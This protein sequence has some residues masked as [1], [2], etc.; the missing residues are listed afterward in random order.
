MVC[1]SRAETTNQVSAQ[2]NAQAQYDLGV[3]YEKGKGAGAD[4]DT[5]FPE[6]HQSCFCK[7]QEAQSAEY[8][9][10][11]R[12]QVAF[13]GSAYEYVVSADGHDFLI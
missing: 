12:G 4:G 6:I 9:V 13:L 3:M 8:L 11:G 1:A 10:A 2:R 7:K 5:M